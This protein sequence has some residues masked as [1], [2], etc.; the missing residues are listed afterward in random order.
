VSHSPDKPASARPPKNPAGHA[1]RRRPGSARRTSSIDV[2]WPKGKRIGPLHLHGQARDIYTPLAGG[3]P[4]VCAQASFEADL[5]EDRSIGAIRTVP[6]HP[7]VAQL[8]GLAGGGGMRKLLARLMPEERRRGDPLYLLLDDIPALNLI[9]DWTWL[10]W[11]PHW[12]EEIQASQA[13]EDKLVREGTCIGFAPGSSAFSPQAEPS[14][15]ATVPPLHHP[16]DPQGWHALSAH[17]QPNTRRV[18]RIDVWIEDGLVQIDAGFQDSGSMPQGGRAAVHEYSLKLTADADT[19]ELLS[20]AAQPQVLPFPECPSATLN[21]A[22]LVGTPIPLLREQV[23]ADLRGVAGCTHLNDALRA[24]ADVPAL[25][26]LVRAHQ[27]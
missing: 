20:L 23:L 1:P 27:G 3:A 6:A 8:R 24:L 12:L 22:R 5:R 9:A 2:T 13:G 16:E 26:A 25:L 14:V 11:D 10:H 17:E 7:A 21:A 15:G 4:L 18:R 19:L